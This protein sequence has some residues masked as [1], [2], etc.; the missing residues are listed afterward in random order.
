MGSRCC[1]EATINVGRSVLCRVQARSCY[2]RC[3]LSSKGP[4][5]ARRTTARSRRR[6]ARQT[7]QIGYSG[8]NAHLNPVCDGHVLFHVA[9]P[10]SPSRWNLFAHSLGLPARLCAFYSTHTSLQLSRL[11]TVKTKTKTT[12]PVGC[13]NYGDRCVYHP[14]VSLCEDAV[15]ADRQR[16]WRRC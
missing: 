6:R 7:Q 8:L 15:R 12:S 11:L 5:T 4:A 13:P 9:P 1:E 14:D 16:C 10:D 2:W 3:R